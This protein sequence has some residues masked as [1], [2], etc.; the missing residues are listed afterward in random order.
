MNES[1]QSLSDSKDELLLAH[2]ITQKIVWTE[3]KAKRSF[4]FDVSQ[5]LSISKFGVEIH[6]RKE[7]LIQ[8]QLNMK[9]DD[10]NGKM[11]AAVLKEIII[12]CLLPKWLMAQI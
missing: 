9:N 4:V 3:W 10:Y 11:P 1:Q 6:K 2:A 5:K 12:V 7:K 8:V